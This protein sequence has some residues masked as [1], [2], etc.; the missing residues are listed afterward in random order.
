MSMSLDF[1]GES[2]IIQCPKCHYVVEVV[3]VHDMEYR[4]CFN[5]DDLVSFHCGYCDLDFDVQARYKLVGYEILDG[6]WV[7]GE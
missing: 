7:Y 1:N 3:D 4:A 5:E 2:V 6:D